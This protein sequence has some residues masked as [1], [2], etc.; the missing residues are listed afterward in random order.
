MQP[1]WGTGSSGNI[2]KFPVLPGVE[3]LVLLVDYDSAGET[4]AETCRRT[5]REAKRDVIRLRPM[6][7]GAD[8]ND[9]VLEKLRAVS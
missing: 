8:F 2:A 9:L 3:Q 4:A 5:W 6:Y 1:A 7:H